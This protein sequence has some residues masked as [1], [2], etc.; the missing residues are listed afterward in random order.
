MTRNPQK[1][2]PAEFTA[3]PSLDALPTVAVVE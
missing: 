3:T 1:L 2:I